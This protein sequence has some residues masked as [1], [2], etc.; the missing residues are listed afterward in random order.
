[1]YYWFDRVLLGV[2]NSSGWDVELSIFMSCRQAGESAM[3]KSVKTR[4][5]NGGKTCEAVR[6]GNNF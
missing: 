1:M 3:E 2:E 4:Y 5:D 6:A